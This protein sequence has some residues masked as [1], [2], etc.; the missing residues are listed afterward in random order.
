MDTS[1]SKI[2]HHI[3]FWLGLLLAV[4]WV[5]SGKNNDLFLFLSGLNFA[6]AMFHTVNNNILILIKSKE[7]N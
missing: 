7:V 2:W 3:G 5:F 6:A 4:L 1:I